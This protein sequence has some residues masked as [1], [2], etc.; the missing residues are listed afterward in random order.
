MRRTLVLIV[1]G[2]VVAP[3][4]AAGPAS[5]PN[6]VFILGDDAG[7]GDFG[8]YGSKDILTP[9]VDRLAAEGMRF[10]NAYSGSAVCAPTRCVLMT[11]LHTGHC[12][13][14]DNT[15]TGELGQF[16]GRPLVFLEP[17]DFTVAEL[18]KG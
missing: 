3:A 16:E 9:S 17:S 5:R 4:V 14:R 2:F 10:S 12:R 7:V 13:R 1:L 15:A 6:I 18:L 8:C 11:G